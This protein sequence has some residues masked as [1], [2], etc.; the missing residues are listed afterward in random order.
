MLLAAVPAPAAEQV[1]LLIRRDPGL[2]APERADV[3]AD[4]GVEYRRR[5]RLADAEVVTV[6]ADEAD[7]ALRTLRR[8]PDVRWAQRDGTVSVAALTTDPWFPSLW[9]LE[10]T[11]QVVNGVAGLPDADMDVPA[12]WSMSTGAGVTVGVIDTGVIAT[13]PDLAGQLATNPGETGGGKESNGIDDDHDGLV[14]DW[15]GWD[16]VGEPGGTLPDGTPAPRVPDNLPD[17]EH[18]HGTHVTGTIVAA[19]GNGIGVTGVAPDARVLPLRVLDENGR[20]SSSSVA[21][22]MDYAG[23]L[24]L[25]VVNMSL[26][27]QGDVPAMGDVARSHPSTLYVVAAGNDALDLEQATYSP[28]EANAPNVLCV[29]ASDSSDQRASFSN[30]GSTSVDLFAPGVTILSTYGSGYAY[31]N[32]TSMATPNVAGVAALMLGRSRGLDA[33]HLRAALLA[34]VDAL[35]QLSG[36]AVTGGRANAEA[37]VRAVALDADADGAGDDG[38]DNCVGVPNRG[39][40]DRD[41]DGVGDA[42]DVTPD[43]ADLDGDGIPALLDHCPLLDGRGTADGCPAPVVSVTPRLPDDGE[44]GHATS[45]G[46]GGGDAGRSLPLPLPL[47]RP[48]PVAAAVVRAVGVELVR[49]RGRGP[50]RPRVRVLV[51]LS[52]TATLD[53]ALQRRDCRAARCRWTPV[54]KAS[55]AAARAGRRAVPLAYVLRRGSYRAVVGARGGGRPVSRSFRVR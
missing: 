11:G 44:R 51:R 35:P 12:A 4:A 21:D 54:A 50:C 6:P 37:A 19:N 1:Q 49:C 16:W 40:Q 25:P 5:L 41:G 39:Q 34:T 52:G 17:D 28:C 42:C 38:A 36:L 33:A 15:R 47:P 55:Q 29:G 14:D 43:G 45:G 26:G 18:G 9:A 2:T 46:S 48:D 7:A 3:R 53:V 20:G 10:N 8:D 30:V 32:G 31:M 24:G 22:A 23:D 27:G 13:H